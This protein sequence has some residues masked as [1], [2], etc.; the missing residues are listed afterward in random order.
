MVKFNSIWFS[1]SPNSDPLV[2]ERWNEEE[3]AQ[4][5]R[6]HFAKDQDRVLYSKSFLRLRDKT[7]VFMKTLITSVLV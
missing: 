1:T 2:K 4:L 5:Y 3:Q 6:K 7:Q